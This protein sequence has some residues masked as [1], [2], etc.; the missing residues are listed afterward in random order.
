MGRQRH[1]EPLGDGQRWCRLRH[2]TLWCGRRWRV[3]GGRRGGGRRRRRPRGGREG[4]GEDGRR[5]AALRAREADSR[6]SRHSAIY[7]GEIWYLQH[8]LWYVALIA[9]VRFRIGHHARAQE[10][11][12]S[13]GELDGRTSCTRDVIPG[14]K[15]RSPRKQLSF[16]VLVCAII[17]FVR[18]QPI[19]RVVAAAV[20]AVDFAD[21]LR[22]HHSLSPSLPLF[23]CLH[24]VPAGRTTPSSTKSPRAGVLFPPGASRGCAVPGHRRQ[25][26]Q[27]APPYR[28]KRGQRLGR[29]HGRKQ[30]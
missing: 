17:M 9:R 20:A 28:R 24:R 13:R 26:R 15:K 19:G 4:F 12:A 7:T 30:G 1:L 14:E 18:F 6:K 10:L 3:G 11:C 21:A 16:L 25:R 5:G 27:D 8:S 29:R 2:L 23:V 22:P